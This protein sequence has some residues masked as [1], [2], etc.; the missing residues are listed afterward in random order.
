MALI[1]SSLRDA[2]ILFVLVPALKDRP[3]F[4]RRYAASLPLAEVLAN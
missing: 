4:K 2:R 3:E 1:Q